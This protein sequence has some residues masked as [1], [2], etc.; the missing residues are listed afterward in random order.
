MKE[1][2]AANASVPAG[3]K[4]PFSLR[5]NR[6]RTVLR[7]VIAAVAAV[8]LILGLRYFLYARS[9]ESTDDAYLEGHVISVSPRVSGHVLRVYVDDNREVRKG[10][11]LVELDPRDYE[12]RLEQ[13]RASLKVAIAKRKAAGENTGLTHIV[14]MAGVEEASAVRSGS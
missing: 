10:D 11:L 5:D 14:S 4:S 3:E 13:A 7:G 6:R 1:P 9:H 2:V 8:A 12:V